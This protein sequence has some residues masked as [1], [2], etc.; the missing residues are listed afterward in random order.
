M[1]LRPGSAIVLETI[2][3]ASWFAFFSSY[4]RASP[5]RPLHPDTL[6]YLLTAHGFQEVTVRSRRLPR[7]RQAG[8]GAGR[9]VVEEAQ[10]HA[11]KLNAL[12][13]TDM[14]TRPSA[15]GDSATA[16]PCLARRS[17]SGP[18][19]SRAV[20]D[21]PAECCASRRRRIQP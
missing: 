16:M 11:D 5:V 1:K 19:R 21:R 18:P 6:S 4:I 14:D 7:A 12:L 9:G 8:P 10:R 17:G 2:N 13:F 20:L 3:V 15:A